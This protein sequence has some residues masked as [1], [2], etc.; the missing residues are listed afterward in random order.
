M[1]L[2]ASGLAIGQ[3]AYGSDEGALVIVVGAED[4]RIAD[5][6]VGGGF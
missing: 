6:Q 3:Y 1:L 5:E 4:I 2:L